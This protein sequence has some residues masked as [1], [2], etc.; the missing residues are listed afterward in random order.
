MMSLRQICN[1]VL[2]RHARLQNALAK[3]LV[4]T[5]S[6]GEIVDISADEKPVY[7]VDDG[8]QEEIARKRNKSR[9]NPHHRNILMGV[10]P[11]DST[12]EW[13]HNTVKYKKRMLGRYGLKGNDEPVGFAWPTPDEVEDAREY[14]R[15]AYPLSLQESWKQLE[16]KRR[17]KAEQRQLRHVFM[18]FVALSKLSNYSRADNSDVEQIVARMENNRIEIESE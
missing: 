6:K 18:S 7:A 1:A 16:E 10:R 2:Y 11:Y 4:A 17:A 14:E 13:Y 12:R 9:L 15:V 5:E 3:R 8:I